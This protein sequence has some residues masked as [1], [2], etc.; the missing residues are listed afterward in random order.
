[1]KDEEVVAR[2]DGRGRVELL[3]GRLENVFQRNIGQ[4]AHA[5]VPVAYS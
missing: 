2:F 5:F 1:M 4:I 3:L